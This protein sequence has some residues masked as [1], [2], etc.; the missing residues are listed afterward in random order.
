MLSIIL[1][2]YQSEKR[3]EK[4]FDALNKRMHEEKIEIECIIIDDGSS[5]SSYTVALEIE[6][7]YKNVRAL[8][9]P[10]HYEGFGIPLIEAMR[11]GCPL[12]SSYGGALREVA[13]NGINFFNPNDLEDITNKI[14]DLVYSEDNISQNIKYGLDRCDHFSWSNCADKTFEAYKKIL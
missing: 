3:I 7:R 11:S 13:G 4:F 1:L 9:Y 5:D 14:E 12:V 2:S 10:S 8:I 6:K